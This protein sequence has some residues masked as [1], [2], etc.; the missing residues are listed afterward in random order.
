MP[1]IV[2]LTMHLSVAGLMAMLIAVTV[3]FLS[4]QDLAQL[5]PAQRMQLETACCWCDGNDNLCRCHSACP[6]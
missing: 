6:S 2:I 1:I 4:L 3:R 5:A